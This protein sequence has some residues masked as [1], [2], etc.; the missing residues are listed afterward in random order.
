MRSFGAGVEC[1]SSTMARRSH[2]PKPIGF[3]RWAIS[4]ACLALSVAALALHGF[5]AETSSHGLAARADAH[6]RQAARDP[7][8]RARLAVKAQD[9]TW[10]E[11]SRSP[12]RSAAWARLSYEQALAAG[13]LD[14]KAARSLLN[15][16]K[17]APY[18]ADILL[19]RTAYVYSNWEKAPPALRQAAF[20]EV[21]AFGRFNLHHAALAK[22]TPFVTDPSGRFAFMLALESG[23]GA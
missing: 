21:S 17:A 13:G 9:A 5:V 12:S 20:D 16:Y 14:D 2:R 18:D 3:A 22:L 4:G 23:P 15:S 11:L 10:V 7:R 8:E 6:M 19:W 1:P